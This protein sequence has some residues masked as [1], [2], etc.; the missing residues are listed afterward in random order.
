MELEALLF[1]ATAMF[2]SVAVGRP[3]DGRGGAKVFGVCAVAQRA[4][5]A[6][7]MYL[8]PTCPG[9]NAMVAVGSGIGAGKDVTGGVA[10]ELGVVP[11]A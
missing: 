11:P 2:G 6:W 4:E 1:R 10:G 3:F 5:E 8:A 9:T 7:V